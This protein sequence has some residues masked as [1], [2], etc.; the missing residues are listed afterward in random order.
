MPLLK[1][2]GALPL[3]KAPN[4]TFEV[5]LGSSRETGRWVIPKG[6]PSKRMSDSAAAAREALQEAGVTGKISKRPYGNY[7]YRKIE[8]EGSRLIDVTVYVLRVK[9][10]K[11]QWKEKAERNRVWFDAETASRKV[12][13]PKLRALIAGLTQPAAKS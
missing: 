3:R 11:K 5:L 4:K 1:Q 2:V 8:K 13:E 6:W 10:E 12:R 9:K 7:R